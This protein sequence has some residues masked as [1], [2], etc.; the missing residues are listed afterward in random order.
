MTI[1]KLA[2]GSTNMHLVD[3]FGGESTCIS[4]KYSF[5]I[6][7]ILLRQTSS[8]SFYVHLPWPLLMTHMQ[9]SPYINLH[10][11][12]IPAHH[13]GAEVPFSSDPWAP[14]LWSLSALTSL[15]ICLQTVFDFFSL[16]LRVSISLLQHRIAPPGLLKLLLYSLSW[17]WSYFVC[18]SV[19]SL[20]CS[21]IYIYEYR[22][23]F[24]IMNLNH[25]LNFPN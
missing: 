23:L 18:N 24:I 13:L 3:F 14:Y 6:T 15:I 25:L 11:L 12:S 5:V 1:F 9:S 4:F 2:T 17:L 22:D 16:P 19:V 21:I 20:S 10:M 7:H 8:Q